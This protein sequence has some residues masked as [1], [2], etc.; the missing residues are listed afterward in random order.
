ME[1]RRGAAAGEDIPLEGDCL[2]PRYLHSAAIA[3]GLVMHRMDT[4]GTGTNS[5]LPLGP[6]DVQLE[7][8]EIDIHITV[9]DVHLLLTINLD[10]QLLES[11]VRQHD[12]IAIASNIASTLVVVILV[13]RLDIN[14]QQ[15]ISDSSGYIDFNISYFDHKFFLLSPLSV[16]VANSNAQAVI[17][18]S[19]PP[20]G[21]AILIV[22]L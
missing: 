3:L 21:G 12:S 5:V 11:L 14:Q 2:A 16:G 13:S 17:T 20:F 4:R 10:G 22:L 18:G 7:V 9:S 15:L 19:V 6:V 8:G 1:K